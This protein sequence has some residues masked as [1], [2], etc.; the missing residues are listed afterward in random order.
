MR[1]DR[2]APSA[3]ECI[4]KDVDIG[5]ALMSPW[6]RELRAPVTAVSMGSADN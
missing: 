3:V 2:V 4:G 1:S 5:D 6:S